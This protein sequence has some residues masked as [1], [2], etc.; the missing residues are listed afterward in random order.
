MI[1]SYAGM[2]LN[3]FGVGFLVLDLEFCG[4]I[5]NNFLFKGFLCPMCVCV[6]YV[7]FS[8]IHLFMKQ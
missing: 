6:F 4:F 8:C 7:Y 5:L 2:R 3:I 1:F